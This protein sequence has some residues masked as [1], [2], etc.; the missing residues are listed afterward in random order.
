MADVIRVDPD[1]EA[2]YHE[3]R[4]PQ[5]PKTA[6]ACLLLGDRPAEVLTCQSNMSSCPLLKIQYILV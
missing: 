3:M 5:A 6:V 4:L 2:T 1:K